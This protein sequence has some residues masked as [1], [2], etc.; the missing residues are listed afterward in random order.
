[1]EG[2]LALEAAPLR[3]AVE[4][5]TRAI[6]AAGESDDALADAA[7]GLD[8]RAFAALR[9]FF[10]VL[11]RA[12]ASFR[13]V[14]GE[15]DYTFEVRDVEIAA[16]RSEASRSEE[17]DVP[18]VGEFLAVLPE[19]RRFELRKD[20]GDI[21]RGRVDED[22]GTE[23]LRAMNSDWANRRCTA[24]L[25]IVTLTRGSRSRTRNVLRRLQPPPETNE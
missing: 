14:A 6:V 15:A 8:G 19:G 2:S 11:K 25:R 24:H 20:D 9:E 3:D 22:L 16:D 1:L 10:A 13:V 7:E 5:V 21:V 12:R 18:V 4:A 17:Q 23:E